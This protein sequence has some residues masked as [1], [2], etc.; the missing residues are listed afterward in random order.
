MGPPLK[1]LE[2]VNAKLKP[3]PEGEVKEE[4]KACS[5]PSPSKKLA[6]EMGKKISCLPG[7]TSLVKELV[8]HLLQFTGEGLNLDCLHPAQYVLDCLCGPHKGQFATQFENW[9]ESYADF[10]GIKPKP[11]KLLAVLLGTQVQYIIIPTHFCQSNANSLI[12]TDVM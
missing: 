1:M 11:S 9:Y 8:E 12:F 10:R 5:T 7:D 2:T 3:K 4:S 6:T